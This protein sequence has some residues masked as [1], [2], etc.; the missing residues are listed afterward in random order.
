MIYIYGLIDPLVHQIAY[1]GKT[2]DLYGRWESHINTMASHS[3]AQWI[4]RLRVSGVQPTLVVL[5][6]INDDSDWDNAE[7]WW[8]S[9]GL[10]IGWPLTNTI[11]ASMVRIENNV[12]G[13]SESVNAWQTIEPQ[14][15]KGKRRTPNQASDDREQGDSAIQRRK[16]IT[17]PPPALIDLIA[18]YVEENNESPSQRQT[19]SAY[20][21][22]TG[23]MLP[24]PIIKQA[25]EI[26][27]N[28]TASEGYKQESE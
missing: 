28:R 7:R 3:T 9:H 10:R 23:K 19:Q 14:S 1:V 4:Q 2:N 13:L 26:V 25:I 22:M 15:L 17:E 8:I 5:E 24:W 11:H 16:S 20:V 27:I 12:S 21:E 18:E 6:A